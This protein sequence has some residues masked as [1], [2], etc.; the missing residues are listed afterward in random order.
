MHNT[1][2]EDTPD[3]TN[4]APID[5]DISAEILEKII[6]Y[7]KWHYANPKALD[8]AEED[9]EEED[10]NAG[11]DDGAFKYKRTDD[12]IEWDKQFIA[13]DNPV[14]FEMLLVGAR[15]HLFSKNT[16]GSKLPQC[17]DSI[18]LDTQSNSKSN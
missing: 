18:G 14:L 6:T 11:M 12:I 13:V 7:L 8:V 10:D 1:V 16:L 4:D 17:E 9:E 2:F 15:S 3:A 5:L